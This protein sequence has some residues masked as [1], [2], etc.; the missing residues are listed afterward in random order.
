MKCLIVAYINSPDLLTDIE[1]I[2]EYY[3]FDQIENN[4]NY[5]VFTGRFKNG[6]ISLAEKLNTELKE[7]QFDIED[8]L[9][10]VYPAL[11]H[12]RIPS[13]ANLIIK[14]KGNKHLRRDSMSQK[15]R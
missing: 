2:M 5:R 13:I 11:I 1:S 4:N 10:I 14:R 3:S 12:N 9:F 7:A 6:A 15:I 8:S